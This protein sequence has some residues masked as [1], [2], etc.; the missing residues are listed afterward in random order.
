MESSTFSLR[1]DEMDIHEILK[2]ICNQ[3][4]MRIRDTGGTMEY[5]LKSQ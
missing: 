3:L 1:K 4:Q 2:E 5:D